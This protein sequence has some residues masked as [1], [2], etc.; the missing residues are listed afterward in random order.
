MIGPA[1]IEERES[2]LVVGPDARITVDSYGMLVVEPPKV[3]T[4]SAR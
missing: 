4:E 1:I 2:T 3:A